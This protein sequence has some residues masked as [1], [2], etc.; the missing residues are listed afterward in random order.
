M[1]VASHVAGSAMLV[2]AYKSISY[3]IVAK[4]WLDVY[5]VYPRSSYYRVYVANHPYPVV[6]VVGVEV[7]EK[8]SGR[9]KR[10][11]ADPLR[12]TRSAAWGSETRG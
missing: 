1:A 11:R 7:G 6:V 3:A 4:S 8:E 9:I 12:S 5:Y 10:K 2:S